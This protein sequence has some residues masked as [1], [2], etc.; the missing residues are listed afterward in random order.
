MSELG[1][2]L[3]RMMHWVDCKVIGHHTGP[4]SFFVCYTIIS[5]VFS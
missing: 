5:S 2:A 3:V 4:F 1:R